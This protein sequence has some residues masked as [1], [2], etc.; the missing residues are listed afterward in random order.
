[1]AGR[2]VGGEEWLWLGGVVSSRR[3]RDLIR[4]LLLRVRATGCVKAVLFAPMVSRAILRKPCVCSGKRYAL[5][6]QGALLF[7]CPRG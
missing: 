1:M 6:E 3:D 7:C 2:G 5:E 4:K